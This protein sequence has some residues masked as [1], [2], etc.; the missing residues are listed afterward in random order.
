M[1]PEKA[2]KTF[3]TCDECGSVFSAIWDD[4]ETLRILGHSNCPG[5]GGT[6]FTEHTP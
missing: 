5:C 6:T 3:A 1:D 2:K 4:P